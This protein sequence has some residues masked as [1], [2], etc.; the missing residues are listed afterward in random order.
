MHVCTPAETVIEKENVG[1]P[2]GSDREGA[3]VVHADRNARAGRQGQRKYGPARC[4]SKGLTRL[5]LEAVP[6][7]LSRAD[8]H[9][10]P[11]I[12]SLKH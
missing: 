1:I 6:K 9:A 10:D 3:E 2:L 11:P 4:L 7:P 12:E 8:A 5:A